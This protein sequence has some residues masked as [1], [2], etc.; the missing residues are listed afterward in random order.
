M[1]HLQSIAGPLYSGKEYSVSA[2][3][4]RLH[5]VKIGQNFDE[6]NVEVYCIPWRARTPY[7]RALRT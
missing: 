1:N 3:T 6:A 5:M 2:G 4:F 7:Q